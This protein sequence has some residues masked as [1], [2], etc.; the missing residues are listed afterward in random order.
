[1]RIHEYAD[2]HEHM[3]T[4]QRLSI[5]HS[6]EYSSVLMLCDLQ[7]YHISLQDVNRNIVDNFQ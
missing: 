7:S 1:M 2:E 3:S 6:D 5:F 4:L